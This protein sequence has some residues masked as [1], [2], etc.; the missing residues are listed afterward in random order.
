MLNRGAREQT[1]ECRPDVWRQ[2]WHDD[3][4]D[5]AEECHRRRRRREWWHC[6]GQVDRVC[7][8][9]GVPVRAGTTRAR[10]QPVHPYHG[11]PDRLCQQPMDGGHV[12]TDE[13]RTAGHVTAAGPLLTQRYGNKFN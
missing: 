7:D 4:H 6:P 10:T 12:S 5:T 9:G 3:T 1:S 2:Q 11:F 8:A 13:Y